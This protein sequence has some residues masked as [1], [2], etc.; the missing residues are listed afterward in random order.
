MRTHA[1]LLVI[2]F[3]CGGDKDWSKEAL[4]PATC[5]FKGH[6]IEISVPDGLES[7]VFEGQ[8]NWKKDI[9]A[10]SYVQI[11]VMDGENNKDAADAKKWLAGKPTIVKSEDA[12]DGGYTLTYTYEDKKLLH[13]DIAKVFG[14][15]KLKCDASAANVKNPDATLDWLVSIC[16]S[17]KEK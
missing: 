7:K 2:A 8:C 14:A 17:L 15:K 1:A 3:G 16:S 4:K 9:S 12:A 11:M 13:A 5:K 6:D 10:E